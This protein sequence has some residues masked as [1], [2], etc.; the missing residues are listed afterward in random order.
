MKAK[1]FHIQ[2]VEIRGFSIP[3]SKSVE[4]TWSKRSGTTSFL[5]ELTTASGVSGYGEMVAFFPTDI[6]L[7]ALNKGIEEIKGQSLLD[8]NSLRQRVLYGGGW[9]R[10]GSMND[11]GAAVWATLEMAMLDA[12]A[13]VYGVNL[14]QLFGG[15]LHE[16]IPVVPNVPVGDFEAMAEYSSQLIKRGHRRLFTKAAKHNHSLNDDIKMLS[17]IQRKVG[18]EIPLHVDV[19]GAWR[20][21]TAI[22]AVR[23][24]KNKGLNIF[25]LEQPVMDEQGLIMLRK[26]SQV[27][28][29]VNELLSSPQAVIA[30]VKKEVADVYILDMYEVGGLFALWY[31]SK[32]LT[33]A[34]YTVVCRAHGGSA[35]GYIAALQVMSAVN[36]APGP[37]QFY[38]N[39]NEED[40]VSWDPQLQDGTI[41]LPN[42]TGIGLEPKSE[43]L[44]EFGGRFKSGE[45]F[46]IYANKNRTV[47]P[48]FP[49]Y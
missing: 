10:T 41:V 20:L 46:S 36:G 30:C 24:I 14:A 11:L 23:E 13:K 28:I 21:P 2:S 33:D 38:D 44:K 48:N 22:S 37:H 5:V 42:K 39:Y 15:R 45:I 35:L 31:I 4:T 32:Y 34:E 16:R 7:A 17:T 9:M 27:A 1:K 26:K 25:C 8:L 40:L 18:N 19:N 3:F 6:C 47:V 43:K 49:K 29:G 12:Q